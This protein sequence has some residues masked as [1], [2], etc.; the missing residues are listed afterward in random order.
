M[1]TFVQILAHVRAAEGIPAFAV[2][3]ELTN[4]TDDM[5]IFGLIARLV[6]KGHLYRVP[7]SERR[8]EDALF[9]ICH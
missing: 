2:M 8:S 5:H 7:T 9:T 3:Q 4:G 1:A 6:K